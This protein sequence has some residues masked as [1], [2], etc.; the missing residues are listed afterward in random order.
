VLCILWCQADLSST[1]TTTETKGMSG[2][3]DGTIR[4]LNLRAGLAAIETEGDSRFSVIAINSGEAEIGDV[5][6]GNLDQ[7]GA[8]DLF[9]RTRRDRISGVIR[10]HT[11]TR[12]DAIRELQRDIEA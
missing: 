2:I 7:D 3:Y 8:V 4:F 12:E 10:L 5:I 1:H 11:A 6:V 9:N